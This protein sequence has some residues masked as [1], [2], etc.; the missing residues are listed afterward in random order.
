MRPLVRRRRCSLVFLLD[1]LF[2]LVLFVLGCLVIYQHTCRSK[3]YKEHFLSSADF[4]STS[5]HG[6]EVA[7]KMSPRSSSVNNQQC[8]MGSCFDVHRCTKPSGFRV[9]VYPDEEDKVAS[10]LYG[11]MLRVIRNSKYYTTDPNEAC[12]FVPSYDTLDRDSHSKDSLKNLPPLRTLK[13]WNGGRN[14]LLFNQYIGTWPDYEEILD[15][16][17]GQAIIARA[18]FNTSHFRH[19]FD[20]SLP[21]MHKEHPERGGEPGVLSSEGNLFPVKRKYLLVFKGKRYLYGRGRESRSSVRHLHNGRDIIMLTSCKHNRDWLKY[22]DE[23]CN[24][25]NQL[26]ER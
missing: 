1:L 26:Y 8:T 12:L 22:L 23:N 16:D 19:G 13:Y 11:K 21:L 17:T 2:L 9:Y 7:L 5:R 15:F 10:S 18:S 3:N 6:Y 14:H 4:H 20:I 25:D 24:E